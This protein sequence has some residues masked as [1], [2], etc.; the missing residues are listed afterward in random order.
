LKFDNQNIC[1]QNTSSLDVVA[2]AVAA[3]VKKELQVFGAK[4]SRRVLLMKCT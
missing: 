2:V 4:S 1:S 3:A